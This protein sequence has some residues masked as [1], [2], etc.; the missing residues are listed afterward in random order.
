MTKLRQWIGSQLGAKVDGRLPLERF[1]PGAEHADYFKIEYREHY[2]EEDREK[3]FNHP[4]VRVYPLG[5][6][7]TERGRVCLF[8]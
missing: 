4:R 8:R 1:C 6:S 3:Y 2:N 5:T 7:C